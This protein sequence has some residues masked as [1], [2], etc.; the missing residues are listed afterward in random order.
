M[1]EKKKVAFNADKVK[2][3]GWF[4][5][6]LSVSSPFPCVIMTPGFSA[7]KEHGLEQFAEVFVSA[8]ISVLIYDNRNFG[9]SEGEPRQEADPK[10]QVEDYSHAI[11][12]VQSMPEVDA[13]RIGIWGVSYS[14]GHV[15]MVA[16]HDRRVKCV[17]SIVPYVYGHYGILQAEQPEKLA[18]L[19]KMYREDEQNRAKGEAPMM[20]PVVSKDRKVLAVMYQPSAYEFFTQVKSWK[21]EVTLKSIALAGEYSPIDFIE[22]VSPIPLLMIVANEDTVNRTEFA[23]KA[24]EKALSPKQLE[25]IEGEHFSPF[26]EHFEQCAHAAR[27]WFLAAF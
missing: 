21:N 12:Y 13:E 3:S 18:A 10:L 17:V 11:D 4:F 6:P 2:L 9:E 25:M 19:K 20:I 8:G 16:A 14:G 1:F 7:L 15:L 27:D 24:Y 26:Q 5:T 23:L 22:Q